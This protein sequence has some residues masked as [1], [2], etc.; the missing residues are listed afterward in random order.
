MIRLVTGGVRSGKSQFAEEIAQRAGE[1]VLYVATGVPGDEKMQ[2]RI[3][4][5][6]DRRPKSWGLVEEEWDLEVAITRSGEWDACL[7]DDL[8]VWT[9]NHVM[10]LSEEAIQEDQG[11]FEA[12]MA[13]KTDRLLDVLQDREAILVTAETGLGGV[14]MSRM[15][16]LFQDTLGTVN[17]QVAKKA[18]EVWLVV[19]GIPYR[20]K[21]G[22]A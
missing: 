20:I 13:E 17:Q 10:R 6:R 4:R 12:Q 7:I 11:G 19:C 2:E 22:D 9:A 18:D 3:A 16:R 14:V 8:G 1:K 5:H 15:G 21:G